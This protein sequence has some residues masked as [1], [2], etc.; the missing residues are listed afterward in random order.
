MSILNEL[1]ATEERFRQR[2]KTRRTNLEQ[3]A[4][5]QIFNIAAN[6]PER[7]R[8][9]IQRLHANPDHVLALQGKGLAF[10]AR[11]PGRSPDRFPRSLERVLHT[12]DL[13]GLRFFEQG[14]RV[15]NAVGRVHIR[16]ERGQ[17]QGY[18]TGFLVSPRLL[19]TNHHVLASAAQAKRSMVE[20]NFQES[21]NA[22]MMP[23][24]TFALAPS[25]LF[26][27]D[28]DLDYA[29]VAVAADAQL[30]TYGWLPLIEE[31]GKLLVGET[32]NIIQHPNGEPK[33]LAIRNNQVVDKLE[34]FLHYQTDT[35]PGSSGSPVF[36]DQWEV[37]ALHHSGVPKRNRAGEVV[38]VDGRVWQE[39]MGEQ[40]IAWEANEGVRVS[41]LVQHI[42]QQTLSAEAEPLRQELL[43]SAAPP[44]RV[45]ASAPVSLPPATVAPPAAPAA[46]A[47]P[48]SAPAA[49]LHAG[50]AIPEG[51]VASWTIPLQLHVSL[52]VGPAAAP[53]PP[54]Q[55]SEQEAWNLFG[56]K[57]SPPPSPS[58]AA[59]PSPTT[60]GADF[61]LDS[62]LLPAF[63]WHTAL[64]L[65]L[66][67]ELAYS[68]PAAVRSQALAWGFRDCAFVEARAAQGFVASSDAVVLVSFR[69]TE[70]T[71]DWLSNLKLVPQSAPGLGRVHAGFWGQFT[72]LQ[73]QLESRLAERQGV[74]LV[75]TGHSLGGA[76]AVLAAATWAGNRPLQALYTYGQPAVAQAEAAA[77]IGAALAGRYHRLVN[78]ADIVPRVPP[79]YRHV[80]QLL[81]FD[82]Q[83]RVTRSKPGREAS[84]S[85]LLES[86]AAPADGPMLADAEFLELQQRLRCLSAAPGQEG[87]TDMISDH[88]I[89]RYLEQIRRQPL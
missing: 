29:L 10:E 79:G 56:R 18:G 82:N 15:A 45:E 26:L 37:V 38:T 80:G 57:P 14:L 16:D 86:T 74:P 89:P 81:Q 12:N 25:T 71:A 60:G 50:A 17:S 22:E 65:G 87:A 64:S 24:R 67:S 73:P 4:S 27:S 6:G 13:M 70:S 23:S 20:F 52:T 9:R 44:P 40:R 83:G 51:A 84:G 35:S 55:P 21:A 46:P 69:G 19:L 76:I 61:R 2:E 59:P 77:S 36:N 75:V 43:R 7:V 11:G 32:V 3:I 47:A 41:R 58:P 1:Q 72:A 42:R 31:Q 34:L 48:P 78:D 62:L 49:A 30:R 68:D 39:W 66:A 28:A 8:Q 53:A 5:G 85:S 63:D 33:Q 88:M 54:A